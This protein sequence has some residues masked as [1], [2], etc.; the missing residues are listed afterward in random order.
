MKEIEAERLVRAW[1][2]TQGYR[3]SDEAEVDFRVARKDRVYAM[4]EIKGDQINRTGS[5]I[6]RPNFSALRQS[7]LTGLGQVT[8]A[9]ARFKGAK[10]VLGLTPMYESIVAKYATELKREKIA[11]LLVDSLGVR[12]VDLGRYQHSF[13]IAGRGHPDGYFQYGPAVYSVTDG[14]LAYVRWYGEALDEFSFPDLCR[15]LGLRIGTDS[16]RRVLARVSYCRKRMPNQALQ[17]RGFARR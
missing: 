11:I 6:G 17:R 13:R 1:Y 8:V 14:K 16:A 3:V 15:R 10:I 5:A 4:V 2:E 12:C 9:R 7:F